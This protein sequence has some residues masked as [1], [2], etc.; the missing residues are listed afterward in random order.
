M[1]PGIYHDLSDDAYRATK[2]VSC[3]VLK[4]FAEAPAKALV[5]SKGS[6]AMTAGRLI[7]SA[8]LEPHKFEDRYAKTDLDRRGTKAWQAAEEEA[9]GRQLLKAEEFDKLATIRDAVMAH[10]TARELLAPGLEPEASMFWRDEA[11][12]LLCR[13][14]VDGL[15]RDQRLIVDVKTTVDASPPE[16]AKSAANYRHHWQ[17]AF[18]RH[19]ANAAPGGFE[20]D[21]FIFIA[22]EREPPFLIGIYELSPSAVAQGEREVMRA[23]REYAECERTGIWPGY[24]PE[25]VMVDLPM[26][27]MEEEFVQ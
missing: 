14:R 25:I 18:Y 22:V 5:P 21:R 27:A 1:L 8:L 15:R 20:V 23:L 16:F 12:K 6:E 19:G 10:P 17:E 24:A 2:A 4:R 11:T 7:H 9:G 26:W 3:S 13:G